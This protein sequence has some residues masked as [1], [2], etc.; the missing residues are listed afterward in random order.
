[1]RTFDKILKF[2]LGIIGFLL[3]TLTFLVF[4]GSIAFLP[5]ALVRWLYISDYY[6]TFFVSLPFLLIIYSCIIRV[7]IDPFKK[8]PDFEITDGIQN[9]FRDTVKEPYKNLKCE[10]K[11]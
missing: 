11:D 9:I 1:M 5:S 10:I 8:S 3:I 4:L 7:I 6:I 2:A